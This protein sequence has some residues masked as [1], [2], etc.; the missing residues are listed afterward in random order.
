MGLH[1][2]HDILLSQKHVDKMDL[3]ITPVLQ[4]VHGGVEKQRTNL[5]GDIH[6]IKLPKEQQKIL[7]KEEE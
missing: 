3:V 4:N 2:L 5:R 6:R 1:L 7:A